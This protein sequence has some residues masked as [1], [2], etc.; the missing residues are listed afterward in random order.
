[1]SQRK[2]GYYR[3]RLSDEDKW[4]IGFYNSLFEGWKFFWDEQIYKDTDFDA[5][6]ET[7]INPEP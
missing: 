1:M 6:D 7:P 5:I 3:V 4:Q 2:S